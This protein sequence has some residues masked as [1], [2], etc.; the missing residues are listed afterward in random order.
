[1][2]ESWTKK[3]GTGEPPGEG[4]ALAG[5][6]VENVPV[7]GQVNSSG[8]VLL[9]SDGLVYVRKVAGC[10]AGYKWS[11]AKGMGRTADET[12]LGT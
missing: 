11:F 9:D 4:Q 1:M 7:S 2:P 8:V 5:L 10:F 12:W 3:P 6:L